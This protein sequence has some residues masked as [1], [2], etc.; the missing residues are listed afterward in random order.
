MAQPKP[1][2]PVGLQLL[3]RTFLE[4]VLPTDLFLPVYTL[5]RSSYLVTLCTNSFVHLVAPGGSCWRRA[6]KT[7]VCF[8]FRSWSCSGVPWLMLGP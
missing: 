1:G 8:A 2:F 6:A 7:M 4:L 3:R 5:H